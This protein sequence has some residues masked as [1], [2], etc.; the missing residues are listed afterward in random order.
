[1]QDG[2]TRLLGGERLGEPARWAWGRLSQLAGQAGS[3]GFAGRAL[4][5]HAGAHLSSGQVDA[6]W[7]R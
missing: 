6:S 7:S 5:I 4:G 1:M 2:S 3:V